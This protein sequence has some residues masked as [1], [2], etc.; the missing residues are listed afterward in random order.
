M[1]INPVYRPNFIVPVNPLAKP[2]GEAATTSSIVPAVR[3]L[4]K[5]QLFGDNRELSFTRDRTT[6]KMVIRIVER[7]TGEVVEQIPPEA[8]LRMMEDLQTG[9]GAQK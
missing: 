4:N 7:Q 3:A 9:R 8:V 1:D 6:H 2:D 5:A